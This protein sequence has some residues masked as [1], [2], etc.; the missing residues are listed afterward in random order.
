MVPNKE[1]KQRVSEKKEVE[2]KD[3]EKSDR[4][5]KHCKNI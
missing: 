2:R 5:Y 4:F 1:N 3:L